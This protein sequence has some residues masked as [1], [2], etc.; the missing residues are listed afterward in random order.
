MLV[1]A[2]A[3]AVINNQHCL[4]FSAKRKK[5]NNHV[6]SI[7]GKIVLFVANRFA[8]CSL[9]IA[10]SNSYLFAKIGQHSPGFPGSLSHIHILCTCMYID[11]QKLNISVWL[12]CMK[13]CLWKLRI[14]LISWLKWN[15]TQ[16]V[17]CI[18]TERCQSICTKVC[19]N[20]YNFWDI[21]VYWENIISIFRVK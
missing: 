16:S 18:C 6:I 19:W 7:F 11:V 8:M 21:L 20:M 17:C 13:D 12:L 5:N 2:R 1:I 4:Y 14:S 3:Q 9:H 10:F 15:C